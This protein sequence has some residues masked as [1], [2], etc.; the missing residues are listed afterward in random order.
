MRCLYFQRSF[1]VFLC[2][3]AKMAFVG[4]GGLS[5]VC[6]PARRIA[7]RI[8]PRGSDRRRAVRTQ[9]PA[10]STSC[11]ISRSA[12]AASLPRTGTPLRTVA[13]GQSRRMS[14]SLRP[15]RA[16]F[17][18][19]VEEGDE[20]LAREVVRC[21]EG[22]DGRC[23]GRPPAG[24]T[25]VDHVVSPGVGQ[26]GFR[27][28]TVVRGDLAPGLIDDSAVLRGVGLLR[29]DFEEIGTAVAAAIRTATAQRVAAVGKVGHQHF[30]IVRRRVAP[31]RS[32]PAAAKR[33]V[34]VRRIVFVFIVLVVCL[35]VGASRPA[36]HL[37]RMR[38]RIMPD[39]R[40]ITEILTIFTARNS[41]PDSR[42]RNASVDVSV[43]VGRCN[44]PRS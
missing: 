4:F 8:R 32:A 23:D 14:A 33:V 30:F 29:D 2:S 37:R 6:R 31:R 9:R 18:R 20:G 10:A 11:R 19:A 28:R 38:G 12:C 42:L 36:F 27:R 25:D 41:R 22:R 21:E 24:R 1:Y 40:R 16:P 44:R 13:P 7:T 17:V 26:V 15:M 43:P 3:S 39:D 34:S 35:P 5:N